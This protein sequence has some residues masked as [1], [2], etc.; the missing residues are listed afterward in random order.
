MSTDDM[1]YD[2]IRERI[3]SE[4]AAPPPAPVEAPRPPAPIGP[5]ELSEEDHRQAAEWVASVKAARERCDAGLCRNH[6]CDLGRKCPFK[7]FR[8]GQR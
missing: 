1:P 7:R 4:A 8:R 6:D 3:L 5:R 2:R